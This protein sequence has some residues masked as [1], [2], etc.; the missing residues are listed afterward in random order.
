MKDGP[1]KDILDFCMRVVSQTV[2]SCGMVALIK[3][4]AMDSFGA[5]RA[6]LFAVIEKAMQSGASAQADRRAGQKGLFDDADDAQ[7]SPGLSLPDL[8]EWSEREKLANEKEVLGYYPTSHPLAEH[9]ATFRTYCTHT[10]TQL[11]DL[12]H[13]TE[14]FLAGMLASL[15]FSNTKNP[16]AGSTHTRY[17]M[18]DLEDMEGM[19]RSILWPEDFAVCGHFAQADAILAVRGAIDRRPGSEEVN[20]IVNELI[21]LDELAKRY[22]RGMMIRLNESTHGAE[23]LEKLYEVLRGYPGDC[24]VQLALWLADGAKVYLKSERLRVELNAQLRDRLDD[25]LGPGNVKLLAAPP[26]PSGNGNGNG[27]GY[28]RGGQYARRG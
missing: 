10:T 16:R 2:S 14:V 5:R 8:P 7:A 28:S 4:G 11:A 17:V 3:S 27:N 23:R 6:Q 18:F 21:P 24:E 25:L 12:P 1:F 13:R 9:Q 20:L 26:R 22:T 15:K 19:V